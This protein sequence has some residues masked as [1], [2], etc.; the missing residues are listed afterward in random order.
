MRLHPFRALRPTPGAAAR[1]ASPPYD[2]VSRAEAA[3]LAADNPLSFLHVGRAD[4]DLPADVDPG[5]ARVYRS[6]RQSLDRLVRDGALVR[7]AEP[8]LYV[9]REAAA[10]RAQTGVVGC[11]RVDEYEGGV[12]RKHERTRPDK[13][14]DRTRHMAHL[15]AHAEPVLLAYRDRPEIDRL[16]AA[17][18]AAPALF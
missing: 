14:D 10:G 8:A 11:V 1:V 9:Y 4:I 5:D 13:E 6:A 15:A 7:E 12:I 17:A 18:T 2:V 3:A 16:V